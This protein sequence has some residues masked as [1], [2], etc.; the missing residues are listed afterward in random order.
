MVPAHNNAN[1]LDTFRSKRIYGTDLV[2]GTQLLGR[3]DKL[4]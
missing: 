2:S 3:A 4:L 1:Q